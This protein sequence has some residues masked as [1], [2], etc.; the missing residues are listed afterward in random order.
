M[1]IQ[2]PVKHVWKELFVKKSNG[3]QLLTTFTRNSILDVW[4]GSKYASDVWRAMN[5][6]LE[7]DSRI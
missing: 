7:K 3:F 4:Q 5:C 6:N 2:N 1:R